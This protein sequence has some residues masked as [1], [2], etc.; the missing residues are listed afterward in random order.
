MHQNYIK[1]H[2]HSFP[3]FSS[4]KSL[5]ENYK[6]QLGIIL[7]YHIT[8]RCGIVIIKDDTLILDIDESD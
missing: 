5:D 7:E 1:S 3:H 2:V 8:T 4:Y 6:T